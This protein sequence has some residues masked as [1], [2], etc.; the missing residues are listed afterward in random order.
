MLRSGA[1]YLFAGLLAITVG[2]GDGTQ[3]SQP[4][5]VAQSQGARFDAEPGTYICYMSPGPLNWTVYVG[6]TV[7][8]LNGGALECLN[9]TNTPYNNARVTFLAGNTSIANVTSIIGYSTGITGVADG[10]TVIDVSA[11]CDASGNLV[12]PG[13]PYA[14]HVTVTHAPIAANPTGPTSVVTGNNCTYDAGGQGG[15]P[16]YTYAWTVDGTIVSGGSSSQATVRFDSDGT[17]L[18]SVTVTDSHSQHAS[19]GL[20]VTSS[21]PDPLPVTCST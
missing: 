20:Y 1:V 21:T 8:S 6:Q 18:V 13:G 3:L 10:Q 5:R 4:T 15:Y 7:G 9:G 16:P 14:I 11:C 17:H 12:D 19:G 2:C